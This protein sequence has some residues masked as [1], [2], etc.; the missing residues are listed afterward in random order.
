[1]KFEKINCPQCG[2][3]ATGTLESIQ[4]WARFH[5][6]DVD[7]GA[8]EYVGHTDVVW[9]TQETIRDITGAVTLTC[10]NNHKWQSQRL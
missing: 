5:V 4:G 6:P 3:C 10:R 8:A 9:D 1:M 2:C 7:E